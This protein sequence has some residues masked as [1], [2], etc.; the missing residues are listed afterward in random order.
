MLLRFFFAPI[1]VLGVLW[2]QSLAQ[3]DDWIAI[4]PISTNGWSVTLEA[5]GVW[6]DTCVP[7]EIEATFREGEMQLHLE[8]PGI[9]VA[10]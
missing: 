3:P 2:N 4:R 6:W 5:S 7:N 8:H 1:V 9:N 10:C